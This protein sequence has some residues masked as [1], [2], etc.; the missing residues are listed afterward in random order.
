M[1]VIYQESAYQ[2]C[3][4]CAWAQGAEARESQKL[5]LVV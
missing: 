3:A 2:V 5:P 1:L 4:G